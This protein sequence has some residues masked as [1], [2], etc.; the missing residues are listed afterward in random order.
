MNLLFPLRRDLK[1]DFANAPH[2]DVARIAAQIRFVLCIE[3]GEL[4]MDPELGSQL[5]QLRHRNLSD[6]MGEANA[7][8]RYYI[9]GPV[10]RWVPEA[11]LTDVEVTEQ[12]GLGSNRIR[13]FFV[14]VD[15]AGRAV[16]DQQSIDL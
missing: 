12:P 5:E 1:N 3:E 6:D 2:G 16:A 14:P 10:G 11:R 7:L 8:A 15:R 13:I 4:E 9:R